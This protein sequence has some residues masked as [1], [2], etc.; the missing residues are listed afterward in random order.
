VELLLSCGADAETKDRVGNTAKDD[1]VR[2]KHDAITACFNQARPAGQVLQANLSQKTLTPAPNVSMQDASEWLKVTLLCAAAQNN[3]IEDL[4]AMLT[5]GDT[6]GEGLLSGNNGDYDQRTALMVA[7]A[8]GKFEAVELL[9][10]NGADVNLVDRWG[11]CALWEC[12]THKNEEI[13]SLMLMYGAQVMLPRSKVVSYLC[14][15]VTNNNM[16]QLE[17]AVRICSQSMGG[18]L[19]DYDMRSPLHLA[20]DE[21]KADLAKVLASSALFDATSRDRWGRSAVDCG[22]DVETAR[23]S[24]E[25]IN[26]SETARRSSGTAMPTTHA[27]AQ[28]TDTQATA[29]PTETETAS[30]RKKRKE[31]R[32]AKAATVEGSSES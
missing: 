15:L 28:G 27:A 21:K 17:Y 8:S 31:R 14:Q 18:W 1:A 22:L 9:L 2:H 5:V 11:A 20:A 16:H 25:S 10:A 26:E 12:I 4:K 29:P 7:C 3:V 30:G 24:S 13:A 23:R 32:K 6:L 19:E